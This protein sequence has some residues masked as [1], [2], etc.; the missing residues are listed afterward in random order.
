MTGIDPVEF[1]E[2]K[3]MIK[4]THAN[5]E[6]LLEKIDT[7][8]NLNEHRIIELETHRETMKRAMRWIAGGIGAVASL[9]AWL[10]R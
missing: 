8:V 6:K 10:M 1:G 9:V 2:L 4:S 5:T 3:G 7:K